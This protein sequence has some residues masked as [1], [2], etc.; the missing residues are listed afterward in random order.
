MP[1]WHLCGFWRHKWQSLK[2]TASILTSGPSPYILPFLMISQW[3]SH[4][5]ISYLAPEPGTDSHLLDGIL[6]AFGL[7]IACLFILFSRAQF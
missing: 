3:R 7:A 4:V 5:S 6:I 1:T 2:H